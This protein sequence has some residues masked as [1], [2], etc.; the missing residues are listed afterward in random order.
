MEKDK[1][2]QDQK[3]FIRLGAVLELQSKYI[4]IT[5]KINTVTNAPGLIDTDEISRLRIR[6]HTLESAI[7]TLQLPI[8]LPIGA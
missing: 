2:V 6:K 1:A 7:R 8:P 3:V 5:N 4:E